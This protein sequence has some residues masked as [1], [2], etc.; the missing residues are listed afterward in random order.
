MNYEDILDIMEE[1]G[2][3]DCDLIKNSYDIPKIYKT[4]FDI[5]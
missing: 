1:N 4:I 3:S 5:G 2:L